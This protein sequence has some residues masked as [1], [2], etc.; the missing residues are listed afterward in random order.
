MDLTVFHNPYGGIKWRLG[1]SGIEVEGKNDGPSLLERSAGRPITIETLWG[2]YRPLIEKAA[3]R[4]SIPVE[5]I[6]ATIATES[7]GNPKALRKE[8]GYVSDEI[9]PQK[10]SPGLMQTLISTASATLGFPVTREWLLI[11]ENSILAG[12]SYLRDLAPKSLL[13]GPMVFASYNAGGVYPQNGPGNRWK[14]RQFPIGTG[15][16]CDRAIKWLN[17]AVA[18]TMGGYVT[19]RGWEWFL[20]GLRSKLLH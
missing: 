19:N 4:Y 16:H 9:T 13:D 10:I 7:S 6:L 5:Y 14:M 11:P 1:Q 2:M 18:V 12:T 3:N 20:K 8:P 15:E 17:D